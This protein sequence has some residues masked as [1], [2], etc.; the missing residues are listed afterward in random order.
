[1]VAHWGGVARG[2]LLVSPADVD[3]EARTPPDTRSFQPMPMKP[4]GYPAIVVASTND[5]FVTEER[6]RAMA[7]A[8][9]ARF[10]SAGSSGHINLDSGHGPWPTGESVFAGLRS[11]AL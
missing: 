7:E 11:R 5:E 8:W 10:H 3:D 6:A 9:G 4:L 1:V 2:A